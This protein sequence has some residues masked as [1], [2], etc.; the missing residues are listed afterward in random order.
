MTKSEKPAFVF[1]KTSLTMRERLT[2]EIACST[3]TRILEILRLRSFSLAVNSF[4][5]GFFSAEIVCGPSAHSLENL[6]LYAK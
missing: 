2:P 1:R 4:L 6:S 5:R 3:L